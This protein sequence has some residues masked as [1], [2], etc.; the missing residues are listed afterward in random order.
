MIEI[1]LSTMELTLIKFYTQPLLI[2]SRKPC[3]C[4]F[5]Y[6]FD[7]QQIFNIKWFKQYFIFKQTRAV[8]HCFGILSYSINLE[9]VPCLYSYFYH[10]L[11]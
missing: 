9:M 2:N 1:N 11:I 6:V 4:L 3:K 8:L 5:E 7:K 10:F